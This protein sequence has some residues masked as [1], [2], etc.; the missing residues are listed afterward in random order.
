MY[1]IRICEPDELDALEDSV[2]EDVEEKLQSV[3]G[4]RN[5][6][7][8]RETEKLSSNRDLYKIKVRKNHRIIIGVIK[9][10]LVVFRVK[11]RGDKD[12]YSNMECLEEMY[13]TIEADVRATV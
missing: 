9:P 4:E 8:H 3:A 10:Y 11:Y 7:S 6:D 5:P 13:D 1:E 12:L 2:R